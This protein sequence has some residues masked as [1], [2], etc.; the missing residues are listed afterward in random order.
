VARVAGDVPEG[1]DQQVL[2]RARR[3][4]R[5]VLTFDRDFGEL[6][7]REPSVIPPGLVFYRF[8]PLTPEQPARLLMD[9]LDSG[10]IELSGQF[11]V[12]DRVRVRQRPL[13]G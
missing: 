1:S 13:P 12:L 8:V 10:E 11:T 3:E 7:F 6:V 5:I 4:D 2:E 9:L